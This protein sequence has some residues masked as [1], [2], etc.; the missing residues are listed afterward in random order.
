MK[1]KFIEVNEAYDALS[2]E[3]KR[4]TYNNFVFKPLHPL[5]AHEIF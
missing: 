4:S 5:G 1:K 3:K 2:E